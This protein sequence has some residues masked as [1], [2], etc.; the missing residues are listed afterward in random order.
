M[1]VDGIEYIYLETRS[2]GKSAKFWQTLGYELVLDLGTAGIMRPAGGG[3]GVFLQ[4]VPPERP[5]AQAVY[6]QA[7]SP[8]FAREWPVRVVGETIESHWGTQLQTIR[9][10]DGREFVLQ[11]D[12]SQHSG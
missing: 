2:W 7:S 3:A 12:P 1:T 9:D 11:Y 4:E 10:P 5:L 8:D 6:L